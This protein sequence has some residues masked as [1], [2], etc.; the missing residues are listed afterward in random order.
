VADVFS[1][2]RNG[3]IVVAIR[4]PK[5]AKDLAPF[6]AAIKQV[7][8]VEG[9]SGLVAQEHH[10]L[11][12]LFEVV[13]GLLERGQLRI[14]EIERDADHRLTRGASPLVGEV[15][16]RAKL[17]QPLLLDL[18]IKLLDELLQRRTFDLEVQLTDWLAED[19]FELGAGLVEARQ[20]PSLSRL[21][22]WLVLRDTALGDNGFGVLLDDIPR[23]DCWL[24]DAGLD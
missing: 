10:D 21:Q 13:H 8:V 19:G 7:S 14:G 6:G 22:L 17:L 9:V 12:R 16:E 4:A 18:A 11:A 3:P 5:W 1:R 20:V 24:I 23:R 15:A 2:E